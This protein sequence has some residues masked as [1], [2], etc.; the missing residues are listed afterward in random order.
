ME[1]LAPLGPV[2]QAGTLSRQPG[3]HRL[4]PGHAARDRASPASSRRCRAR[5]RALVDGLVGAARDAGVPLVGDCEGG[6]FGFFF[7]DALP[8]NYGA[9][10][11]TD[12]ERFNRFFHAHAATAACTSRRRCTRPASSA[13]RTAPTTSRRRSPRAASRC[14][15][16]APK[17]PPLR[18]AGH[19]PALRQR[20]AHPHPRHLRHLHGRPRR[21]RARGRP[22]VTGC[23]ANV[24]PPMSDQLRALGIE[25]IEG[26]GAEQLALDARPVRDRQRRHARQP[27]DRGDPRRRRCPTRAAR[28][29]WPRTCCRAA[30]CWPW[31][32]RTARRP[33][34]SMLAW[35]LEHAGLEPG[36][37][38]GGVPRNFGV[39]A[40]ARRAAASS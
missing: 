34:P 20:H 27:A 23:D 19:R 2:Y 31:P 8:Q 9:V 13:R 30:T 24:Y 29:G 21:A 36:F 3:G 22:P 4:R 12:K 17:R 40:R 7:A 11:A 37:L 26:Y 35:I 5:T 1:Q 39:S 15:E 18:L 14:A 16:R 6:M 28:S 32:A 25:L 10:M 38:V 33:P